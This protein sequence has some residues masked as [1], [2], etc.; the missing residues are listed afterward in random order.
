MKEWRKG[1]DAHMISAESRMTA[2]ELNVQ[3]LIRQ[4]EQ[5]SHKDKDGQKGLKKAF[6]SK[7]ADLK[8]EKFEKEKPGMTFKSWSTS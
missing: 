6:G 7:G 4:F 5:M 1:V 8:P 2:A 3:W